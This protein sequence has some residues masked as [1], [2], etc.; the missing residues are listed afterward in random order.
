ML[1]HIHIWNFAIV[2][3]L[4]LAL[5]GGLTVLTGET[6]A[7][8]SI[9]L[10]AL[11]LALG[12]RAGSDVVRH[13]AD[14]AE[15]SVSFD[16]SD[17]PV[18]EAWLV[19]HELD[20]ANEC[21]IRRTISLKGPSKAFINGKPTPV[22]ML[23]EL[24]EMLVDLHGQ[25]EHQ[26]LLKREL[27]GQLVDNFADNGNLLKDVASAFKNWQSLQAEYKRLSQAKT[28]R[29]S[30][31]DLLRYQV[32]ELEALSLKEGELSKMELDHRRLSNAS[33]LMATTERLIQ[34]LSEADEL[35]ITQILSHCQVDV[36]SLQ[37][38]DPVFKGV[39]EML[40]SAA[41]QINEASTE[42]R[43]YLSELELDPEQLNQLE[44]GLTEIHSLA[45]KHRIE[46]EQL[47]AV[48]P[49]L[50]EELKEL[51]EADVRIEKIEGEIQQAEQAYRKLAGKLSKQRQQ[52]AKHLSSHITDAMQ[53]LSMGGGQFEVQLD[54]LPED[55]PTA[56]GM[57]KIEF[58]VSANPG[59]PVKP[60]TKVASGG[61]ISRISLAIQVCTTQAAVIPTLVFDEV[62]VGIGGRVAEIVGQRLRKLAGNRQVLCVTHLPQVAALGH[63]H[64]QVSKHVDGNL[65]ITQIQPLQIEQRVDELARMLGGL[66]ITEQTISHAR[67]MIE[68]AQA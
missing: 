4:D 16:T 19:E 11:G 42:L 31:L 64:L 7:G 55:T 30:R 48:L 17:N 23:R 52:A 62:D 22:S 37:E 61:E 26:S 57:E 1:N 41:I 3:K 15:V 58:L 39:A 43:H 27:Q 54:S 10:N 49:E 45:R 53:E 5:D 60:L 20:S 28:D 46:P 36:S 44:Q 14:K 47:H 21:I 33:Q 8:K 2:E 67:E 25:H 29:D 65:T 13:G 6:G 63:H 34:Q 51:E 9:L 68:K 12:D 35:A 40:D 18:A 59:Q 32:Q 50:Q 38:M 56:N 66:E 24:G